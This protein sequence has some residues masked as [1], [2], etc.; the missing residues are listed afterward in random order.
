MELERAACFF[1][2]AQRAEFVA[3]LAER[4]NVAFTST[5]SR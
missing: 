3:D 2:F 4:S 1:F 5:R